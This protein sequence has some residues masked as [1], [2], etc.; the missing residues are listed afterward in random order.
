MPDSWIKDPS[1]TLDYTIDWT[2]WLAGDT[3]TGTPVWT[4]PAGLTKAD[5][6]HTTTTSTVWIS[7]GTIGSTY[8]LSVRVTTTGGRT[9]D[10][11]IALV[12]ADR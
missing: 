3:I 10:R 2:A 4:V 8:T 11:S 5:E 12:I 7:G 1:A 6:S 9:D